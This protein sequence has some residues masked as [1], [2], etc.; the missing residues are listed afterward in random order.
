[1]AFFDF[2]KSPETNSF[3]GR[4]QQ[5]VASLLPNSDNEEKLLVACVAGLLA[6]VAYIDFKIHESELLKM[7]GA[8][9]EWTDLDSHDIQAI[10]TLAIEEIKDLAGLENH[11]YCAPLNELLNPDQRYALLEGLFALAASDGEVESRESEEIRLITQGLRLEHKH[12]IAAR[13]TVLEHLKAL[14]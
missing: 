1:M 6:R 14:K 12:F 10:V 3:A 7:R 5:K 2:F 11:T 9:N 4:L 8:L 13:A